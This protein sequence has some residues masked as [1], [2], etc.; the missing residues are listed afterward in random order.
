MKLSLNIQKQE[1]T[2]SEMSGKCMALE[3]EDYIENLHA[4]FKCENKDSDYLHSLL[5]NK[6]RN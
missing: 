1:S 6:S 3:I 5:Q 2:I 4:E